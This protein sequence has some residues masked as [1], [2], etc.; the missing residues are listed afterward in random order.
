MPIALHPGKPR[1]SRAGDHGRAHVRGVNSNPKLTQPFQFT[2]QRTYSR[3]YSKSMIHKRQCAKR[4]RSDLG[5]Y[6]YLKGAADRRRAQRS[7]EVVASVIVYKCH[8]QHRHLTNRFKP[9]PS[10]ATTHEAHT[11]GAGSCF[12]SRMIAAAHVKAGPTQP[13]RRRLSAPAWV[14]LEI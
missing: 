9:P 12:A 11:D 8:P 3:I 13:N 6:S 14:L 4:Y 1:N 2:P 5:K 10:G 7:V